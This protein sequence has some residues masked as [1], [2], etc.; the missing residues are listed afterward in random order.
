MNKLALYLVVAMK[1]I[2]PIDNHAA[3]EQADVTEA[4]YALIAQDIATGVSQPYVR[5]LPLPVRTE[6]EAR[7]LTGLVLVSTARYE[8]S[9]VGEVA[10]CVVG[11]DGGRSWSLFQVQRHHDRAC[12]SYMGATGVALE[13][14]HESFRVTRGQ[15]IEERLAEYTDGYAWKSERAK[16]R[17]R[18]RML[19]ALAYWRVHPFEP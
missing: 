12:W 5:P 7:A 10:D 16:R 11:G 17:S 3:V 14:V 18:D 8:S 1:A 4:R 15:P 9:F 13:M 19:T 2:Y 6:V